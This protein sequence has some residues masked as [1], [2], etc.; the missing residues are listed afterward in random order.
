MIMVVCLALEA[1]R[2]DQVE[3][4]NKIKVAAMAKGIDKEAVK[5]RKGR[6]LCVNTV[7]DICT[8]AI[9]F[10]ISTFCFA[11]FDTSVIFH[12]VFTLC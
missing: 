7:C 5:K 10:S 4:L 1:T 6:I 2:K 12:V 9:L 3:Q 8:F 11:E